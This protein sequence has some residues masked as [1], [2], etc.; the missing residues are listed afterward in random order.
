MAGNP[1]PET[2]LF[3]AVLHQALEDLLFP[4]SDY[5]A[6]TEANR[7]SALAFLTTTYGRNRADR[8]QICH[9]AGF[10]PDALRERIIA[11]LEGAPFKRAHWR[12]AGKIK[13]DL[14]ESNLAAART[15]WAE[16]NKPSLTIRR[17]GNAPEN[18]VAAFEPEPIEV[19][20][21]RSSRILADL[22]ARKTA[23]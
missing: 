16:Q 13:E 20:R 19:I 21:A 14:T 2:L 5:P 9:C 10:C 4:R 22:E 12:G 7:R 1:T 15:L 3:S 6:Q 17:R 18:R 11:I 8:E 23:A